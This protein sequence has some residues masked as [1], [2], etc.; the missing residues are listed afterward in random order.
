MRLTARGVAVLLVAVTLLGL[1]EWLGYPLFRALSCVLFG[2]LLAAVAVTVRRLRVA[3]SREVYPDRVRRGRPAL[4]KLRVRNLSGTRQRGSLA[5]DRAGDHVRAV[6]VPALVAASSEVP[7]AYELPTTRRG[8]MTVGPLTLHRVDPLGLARNR[9]TTGDTATLWVHPMRYP[10]RAV[11]GGYPRHHHVGRSTETLRGSADLREVREYVPGDEVRLLHWKATARTGQLMV[12]DY[13]DP[14]QPR[15]TLLL[16]TRAE[17]FSADAFEEAV[18]LAAS[19]LDACALAGHH[20]RLVTSGGLDVATAGGADA[21]RTLLDELCQVRQRSGLSLAPVALGARRQDGMLAVVTSSTVDISGAAVLR[22]RFS[23]CCVFDFG[24]GGAVP[25][26]RVL[27]AA[28]AAH[29]V[30]L[31]NEVA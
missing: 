13:A 22:S 7:Y 1:G 23:S 24:P 28:T 21:A 5:L 4:A 26:L 6:R 8:R 12:R 31:W 17:A 15:F 2:L 11:I 25:G 10:A 3:V 20:S 30:R 18:D 29:A 19:L 14:E 16:D 9:M 27:R